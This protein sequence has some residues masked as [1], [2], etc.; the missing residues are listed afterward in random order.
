[1]EHLY[2]SS[3]SVWW[4]LPTETKLVIEGKERSH[5]SLQMDKHWPTSMLS[6]TCPSCDVE[7]TSRY[8]LE[9]FE[10]FGNMKQAY[11][12]DY[13]N[14]KDR[15]MV[16][17]R[18][19]ADES[20]ES[21]TG[22]AFLW[23]L[24]KH[25]R[26]DYL[27]K[28]EA[29]GDD[30]NELN[31][32]DWTPSEIQ[33]AKMAKI[34]TYLSKQF[35][36]QQ[37]QQHRRRQKR[38]KNTFHLDPS[39]LVG[40]PIRLYNPID[41]SYHSG[42]IIDFKIDAPHQID[43]PLSN[44]K[45]SDNSPVPNIGKLTDEKV[46]N[47]LFL[48]RFREGVEGRKMAVHKWIYLEEH[49]VTVGTNICWAKVGN[50][51]DDTN[52]DDDTFDTDV[53]NDMKLKAD[54]YISPYQPVQLVFRS[55][56]EMI[57]VQ[58]LNTENKKSSSTGEQI[59]PSLDVLAAGFG[60]TLGYVRLSLS[61]GGAT[62][63]NTVGVA[64]GSSEKE[65][66]VSNATTEKSTRPVAI[67]LT[68]SNPPWLDR[69]LHRAQLSDVDV[70]LGLAMACMEKEE[71]RRIRTWRHLSVSH[72]FQPSFVSSAKSMT[73]KRPVQFRTP[74]TVCPQTKKR[75]TESSNNKHM[76]HHDASLEA[77]ASSGCKKCMDE[78]K[79]KVKT[80]QPHDPS[81]QR[82][83]H[84]VTSRLLKTESSSSGTNVERKKKVKAKKRNQ[85]SKGPESNKMKQSRNATIIKK[86]KDYVR[87]PD[88]RPIEGCRMCGPSNEERF[89]CE[90]CKYLKSDEGWS[91]TVNVKARKRC[92]TN[93]EGKS[94][95]SMKDFLRETTD[96]VVKKKKRDAKKRGGI[97]V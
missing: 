51:T 35:Q 78:H 58:N 4:D 56:L 10:Q 84:T 82:K 97:L 34:L 72:L 49:A 76:G 88:P 38:Q 59:A 42:R 8:L 19:R 85:F 43:E 80:T 39:H 48:I 89:T 21:R 46:A 90:L 94:L 53:Y 40:M 41:N 28:R 50:E 14:V 96:L 31:A 45:S 95:N 65:T 29:T 26:Q 5:R 67:P 57:P 87:S 47:T 25:N 70:A 74:P 24:M 75:C 55:M 44:L 68:P 23:H 92:Y 62:A 33:L 54:D 63:A 66:T 60:Q 73:T 9:Y 86:L 2:S 81:C 71:E 11:Y 36:Q 22:E 32:W 93:A 61:D 52:D 6:F 69:I 1:M 37:K 13:L 3:K 77:A 30:S 83:R 15:D 20:A 16:H 7:G 64:K 17:R 91:M 12:E 27:N 79:T 18:D